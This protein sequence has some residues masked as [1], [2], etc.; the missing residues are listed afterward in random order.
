[1]RTFGRTLL[2]SAR[3]RF[4]YN[5]RM[6]SLT[7]LQ[8]VAKAKPRSIY[9]LSGDEHFL[10]RRVVA[11]LRTLVLGVEDDGFGFVSQEGDKANWAAIHDELETLPFLGSRRLVVLDRADPF[12]TR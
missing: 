7:F 9:V 5:V 8:G 10:K 1:M 11:A 12:V 3:G 4:V 2:S 6:D